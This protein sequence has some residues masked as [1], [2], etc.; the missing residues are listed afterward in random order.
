MHWDWKLTRAGA[1]RFGLMLLSFSY[2]AVNESTLNK[3]FLQQLPVGLLLL[4]IIGAFILRH[5]YRT[6]K[7]YSRCFN[8]KRYRANVLIH[9]CLYL[10]VFSIAVSIPMNTNMISSANPV[11]SI[12][13]LNEQSTPIK[14]SIPIETST[15]IKESK[16]NE[17]TIKSSSTLESVTPVAYTID[18]KTDPK[19]AD[20]GYILRGNRGHI[21]YTVYGGLNNHLKVLSRSISYSGAPPN[22]IDFIL[23]DLNDEDQKQ[24]L[25]PLVEQIQSIT[26]NKDDQA[27]I[28]V[29][30]VQNL[31]YDWDSFKSKSENEKY[32]YEVLYTGSGVC[33]EKSELLAYLLRGLGYSVT[34]FR[35]DSTNVFPGH[36]A[37][38]VKCPSQYSYKNTGYCFVETTTPNIITDSNGDYLISGTSDITTKL[39]DTFDTLQICDG[40]SFDSVSE[41]YND[42]LIYNSFEGKKILSQSSYDK[43]QCLV[44]KYGIKTKKN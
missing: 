12:N 37:V 11:S 39:P 2:I 17:Q 15:P 31:D 40:N 43:W 14:E 25:D 33:S 29:S 5:V 36:D 20:Y 4:L 35:F 42:A 32:P 21:T 23:R 44:K 1:L 10:I 18:F 38:G 7:W 6:L 13:P 41:E 24:F 9:F 27:R 28:A 16:N 34:I 26:Q 30:L 8:A 3:A 22:D 19:T